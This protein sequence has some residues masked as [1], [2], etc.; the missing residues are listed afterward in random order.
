MSPV[1]RVDQA[2]ALAA[3]DMLPETVDRTLRTRY[4]QLPV[5]LHTAGL[6]ATYAFVL[7]KK[8][9]SREGPAYAKVA[10]GIRRHIGKHALIDRRTHWATDRDLLDALATADRAAYARASAEI[11][12]LAGWLS[13]LAEARFREDTADTDTTPDSDATADAVSPTGEGTA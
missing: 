4:K 9:G 7:S 12:S 10:E 5:M 3:M 13:R 2:M 8:H 6:A 1:R 11:S